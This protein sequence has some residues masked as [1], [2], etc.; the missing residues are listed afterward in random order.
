MNNVSLFS[1]CVLMAFACARAQ[2]PIVHW[3][4]ENGNK[5]FYAKD[6]TG[7]GHHL[8]MMKGDSAD[9]A[10]RPGIVGKALFF[11]QGEVELEAVKSGGVFNFEKVTLEAI[12]YVSENSSHST[13]GEAILANVEYGHTTPFWKQVARGWELSIWPG[14]ILSLATGN[15]EIDP[16]WNQIL[17]TFPLKENRVHYVSA[18]I[19][20]AGWNRIYI[21]GVE[22]GVSSYTPYLPNRG[23]LSVAYSY[24]NEI[25]SDY[26]KNAALDEIKVYNLAK[27]FSMIQADYSVVKSA[28]D[29][30]NATL[31]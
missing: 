4:F 23:H 29:S 22:A 12:V 2:L 9:L 28:I 10:V 24:G 11:G 13:K 21:D 27:D 17:A 5:E 6:E 7:N 26:L 20:D 30:V 18:V 16:I 25:F 3:S 14:N 1:S 19:N 31:H 8:V 15:N